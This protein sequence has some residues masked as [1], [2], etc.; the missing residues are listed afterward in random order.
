MERGRRIISGKDNPVKTLSEIN[1]ED[2]PFCICGMNRWILKK[3]V[4]RDKGTANLEESSATTD[5]MIHLR[6]FSAMHSYLLEHGWRTA[7]SDFAKLTEAVFPER[8]SSRVYGQL[9]FSI[10]VEKSLC[11]KPLREVKEFRVFYILE[12]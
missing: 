4:Q 11:S 10:I 6:L 8:P 2:I 3:K 12:Q 5:Q 1:P 7:F 9:L